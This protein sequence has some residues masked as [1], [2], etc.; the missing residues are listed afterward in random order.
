MNILETLAVLRAAMGETRKS[1]EDRTAMKKQN[2]NRSRDK[3]EDEKKEGE[4]QGRVGEGGR[5]LRESPIPV[6]KAL[7]KDVRDVTINQDRKIKRHHEL[8]R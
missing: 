4:D 1:G 5:I 7:K 6:F 2:V 3:K 8:F